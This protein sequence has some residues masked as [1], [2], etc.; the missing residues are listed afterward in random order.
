MSITQ[1]QFEQLTEMG[2]SLWQ[3]RTSD[4]HSDAT[5]TKTVSYLEID[6][7]ALTSQTLFTDILLAAG[8]TIGEVSH[9]GDHLDLGLFNW[10]FTTEQSQN[11]SAEKIQWQE[12]KLVTPSIADISKSPALKKQ[13]WHLLGKQAQ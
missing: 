6:L 4:N 2:I 12:Q 5:K 10:Y 8:L 9:Q 11:Q 13:L 3:S 1:N 7:A